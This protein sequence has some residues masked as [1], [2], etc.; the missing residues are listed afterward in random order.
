MIIYKTTNKINGKFYIGFDTKD[1]PNYF[2]SGL[3][4]KA[5]IKKYGKENFIKEVLEICENKKQLSERERY[6]IKEIRARELGYNIAEGGNGG[7]LGE[8]V[9]RKI[10]LANKGKK[11]LDMIG[12]NNPMNREEV[13]I[14]FIN[15]MSR[16]EVREKMKGENNPMK[17]PEN[18]KKISEKTMGRN[19]PMYGKVGENNPNYGSRR[20]EETKEKM[21][22]MKKGKRRPSIMGE[23]NPAKRSEVRKKISESCKKYWE[24]KS[25]EKI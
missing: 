18:R 23:N 15:P 8:E 12:K 19:N 4:I 10:G 7:N 25:N 22:K 17:R 21:S 16:P 24:N 5:A 9:N 14:K 1:D 13:K 20:S 11:R 3:L 2:G 6:W